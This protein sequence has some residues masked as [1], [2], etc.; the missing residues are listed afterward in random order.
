[1]PSKFMCK[2]EPIWSDEDECWTIKHGDITIYLHHDAGLREDE[3]QVLVAGVLLSMEI[4]YDQI[5]EERGILFKPQE[6]WRKI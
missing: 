2:P 6:R 5:T 3:Q 4:T 1:M